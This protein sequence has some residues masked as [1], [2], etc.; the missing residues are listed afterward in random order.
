MEF[1][2]FNFIVLM[3]VIQGFIF[4]VVVG[5]SKKY[6]APSTRL[7]ALLIVAFSINNLQFFFVDAGLMDS[8]VLYGIFWIPE[9]VLLGPLLFAYGFRF[10]YPQIPLTKKQ[11]FWL[12]LPFIL[13]LICSTYFKI[14][15]AHEI[16]VNFPDSYWIFTIIVEF[17][18]V[19][20]AAVCIGWLLRLAYVVDRRNKNFRA[21]VVYPQLQWFRLTLWAFAAVDVLWLFISIKVNLLGAPYTW[22]YWTWISLSVLIYWLGHIGIYKFG[23]QEERKKIRD[24]SLSNSF[25]VIDTSRNT[26]LTAFDDLLVNQKYFLDPQLTLDSVAEKLGV[27]KSYLSRTLNKEYPMG[28]SEYVN[29]LRVNEAKFYLTNK[30]FAQYTLVAIGLE[31]GFSSKTTF[32]SAFKRITGITPSE[33]R[34]NLGGANQTTSEIP[35]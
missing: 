33:Y 22:W 6:K 19:F 28:F 32:N 23:I 16:P 15:Y 1:N 20:I 17:A 34:K 24:Y 18:G 5:F 30:D 27:S 9:H 4:G 13:C 10:L 14:A 25:N 26:H 35:V 31:A 3:G 12:L 7:L 21:D 2:I 8:R 29:S 11:I